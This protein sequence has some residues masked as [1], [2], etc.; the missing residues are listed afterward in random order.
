MQLSLTD[1]RDFDSTAREKDH[2]NVA[3]VDPSV[4]QTLLD[5]IERLKK[6]IIGF[7]GS[8]SSR[9]EDNKLDKVCAAVLGG[10]AQFDSVQWCR[11]SEKRQKD[12]QEQLIM[13]RDTLLDMATWRGEKVVMSQAASPTGRPRPNRSSGWR[14]SDSSSPRLCSRSFAKTGAAKPSGVTRINNLPLFHWPT[15]SRL[16][17][18]LRAV[19]VLRLVGEFLLRLCVLYG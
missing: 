13:V 17:G 9:L 8:R 12:L 7:T 5:D 19:F 3:N 1:R 2:N 18:L 6:T 10:A 4:I 16:V 15:T 11:L 14:F